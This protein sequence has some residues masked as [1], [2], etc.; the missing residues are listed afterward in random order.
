MSVLVLL[1]LMAAGG[2]LGWGIVRR[3]PRFDGDW[4]EWLMASLIVG[5]VSLG[6][7]ALFL[8]EIGHFSILTLTIIYTLLLLLLLIWPRHTSAPSPQPESVPPP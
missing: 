1:L 8:A 4:L 6:T 5:I 3:F 7:I 2:L